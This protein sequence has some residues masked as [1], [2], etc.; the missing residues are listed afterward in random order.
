VA[1]NLPIIVAPAIT[2][3]EPVIGHRRGFDPQPHCVQGHV[4]EG[5]ELLYDIP[6]KIANFC[7]K[8]GLSQHIPLTY[9][10]D[11]AVRRSAHPGG[12]EDILNWDRDSMTLRAS[13]KAFHEEGEDKLEYKEWK[14]GF[15]R[16]LLIMKKYLPQDY[17]QWAVHML[18][19][20]DNP[21][22]L[23]DEWQLWLMYDI[24]GRKRSTFTPLD[25][26]VFQSGI[27]ALVHSKWLLTKV[28]AEARAEAR[29]VAL[30]VTPTV[31]MAKTQTKPLGY[32]SSTPA[33]A[34]KN[35]A[36]PP[37]HSFCLCC[38]RPSHRTHECTETTRIDGGSLY[39]TSK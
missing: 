13:S 11:A 25:P 9:L 33:T 26:S 32:A 16:W 22:A 28:S 2:S 8:H 20:E 29:S 38:G 23:G 12:A 37:G 31:P 15:K 39:I 6:W 4:S 7:Q 36:Q 27:H 34:K 21:G 5:T 17:K 10:T 19:I 3:C 24:E 18:T 1:A 30:S 35:P 14:Q